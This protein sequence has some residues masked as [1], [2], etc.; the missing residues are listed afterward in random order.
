MSV[1]LRGTSPSLYWEQEPN[2]GG[3]RC[4]V[5]AFFT[6]QDFA[7]WWYIPTGQLKGNYFYGKDLRSIVQN[8]KNNGLGSGK[9]N[10]IEPDF[11]NPAL[12]ELG[13]YTITIHGI[14][15]SNVAGYNALCTMTLN[16]DVVNI[17]I[18]VADPSIITVQYTTLSHN[19][20]IIKTYNHPNRNEEN[21]L[22]SFTPAGSYTQPKTFLRE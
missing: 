22:C 4:R 19:D 13:L 7:F 16:S 11:D 21:A 17:G 20:Y 8:I 9:L 6:C 3:F 1:L 18:R 2:T 14:K 12:D 5:R 10:F 15:I